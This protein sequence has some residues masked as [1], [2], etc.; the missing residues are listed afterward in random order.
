MKSNPLD[1]VYCKNC[2]YYKYKQINNYSTLYECTKGNTVSLEQPDL[3]CNKPCFSKRLFRKKV[4][5]KN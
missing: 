5:K 3:L 4:Q 2:R 1:I